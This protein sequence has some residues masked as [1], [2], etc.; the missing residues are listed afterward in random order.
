M[1]RK[2]NQINAQQRQSNNVQKSV[3]Q[4]RKMASYLGDSPRQSVLATR[5][6]AA[7]G[8]VI[9]PGGARIKSQGAKVYICNTEVA[10]NTLTIAA[11]GAAS[12]GVTPLIPSSFAWLTGVAQNYSQWNW[13]YLKISYIPFCSTSTAGRFGMGLTYDAGDTTAT[14]MAQVIQL[15]RSVVA[16]VWGTNDKSVD[17][18]VPTDR[19]FGKNYRY[20]NGANYGALASATDKNVYCPALV[21]YGT[22]SGVAGSAGTLMVE[23]EVELF[24]P[25]VSALN[26]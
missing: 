9:R 3:A 11:A 7:R 14:T 8:A 6:P 2:Q 5:V 21:M 15:D 4:S 18:I 20:I 25:M 16:P 23:Y 22:D 13:R 24:D 19:L 10:V 17:I 26:A 12:I 1:S